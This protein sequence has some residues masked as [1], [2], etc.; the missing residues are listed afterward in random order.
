MQALGLEIDL[1]KKQQKFLR[2]QAVIHDL[3]LNRTLIKG[4]EIVLISYPHV[5]LHP[6]ASTD[7]RFEVNGVGSGAKCVTSR[8]Q[9]RLIS[10]LPPFLSFAASSW[11]NFRGL[12]S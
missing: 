4:A 10:I 7:A 3:Q 9:F 1:S 11:L 2:Y 5:G 12:V 6:L 8:W